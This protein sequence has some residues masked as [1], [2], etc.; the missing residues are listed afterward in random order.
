MR[1]TGGC[2][3]GEFEQ[4]A[5]PT[6][7]A[8]FETIPDPGETEGD[9]FNPVTVSVTTKS[10]SGVQTVYTHP[11]AEIVNVEV[12]TWDFTFPA[13]LTETGKWVVTF[14]GGGAVQSV[15]FTI[16]RAAVNV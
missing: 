8:T 3:P 7:R 10:P 15:W 6:I 11:T 16:V 9:P 5:I 1:T 12:G 13:A 14:T 2:G 4:G